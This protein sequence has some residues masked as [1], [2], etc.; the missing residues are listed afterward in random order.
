MNRKILIIL[1][2]MAVLGSYSD[3]LFASSESKEIKKY[4]KQQ[5]QAKEKNTFRVRVVKYSAD[6]FRDPFRAPVIEE[7][8]KAVKP[9]KR[10][11][12]SGPEVKLPPLKISGVIWGT[13]IPQAIINNKV[14]KIG[15]MIDGVKIIN[16]SREE[17]TVSYQSREF[18]LSSPAGSG[19]RKNNH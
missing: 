9:V 11:P 19:G 3:S 13:K 14:V 8:K 12:G 17:I 6:N 1:L 18:K 7:E 16:I 5:V 4:K 10:Y 2:V 15:D